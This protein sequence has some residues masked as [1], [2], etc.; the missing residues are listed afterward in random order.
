[1][2]RT[3]A[4]PADLA[5][6]PFRGSAA[7]DAGLTTRYQLRSAAWER[8]LRD[9]YIHRP[10]ADDPAIRVEALKLGTAPGA[11]VCGLTAAWAY[12]AWS[13]PP[14][15]T[16]PLEVTRPVRAPG[17]PAAGLTRRRLVL[18]GT[19]D[20]VRP[21]TGLSA[22]DEDV[23]ER[24]G[25]LFTSTFRTCFDLMRQR[26]LVEAVA[27]ADSF[28]FMCNMSIPLLDAYCADRRRW[29]NVRLA[30]SAVELA[31]PA[32]RSPGESRL[33]M[34]VVLAGFDEPLV[35]VPI[36]DLD[37]RHLATPDLL[38]RSRRLVG[39]EYDGEYHD[40]DEQ[41]AADRLRTNRLL[42]RTSIPLLRYDRTAVS[43]RRAVIVA[44]VASATGQRPL[45]TLDD[46]D[47]F[48]GPVRRLA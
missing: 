46:R 13:P 27:I 32:A 39:L 6:G 35:N 25:L 16:V 26:H 14:G 22:L 18:R 42:A 5:H 11:V 20:L 30:R 3:P 34:V 28:A 2:P 44:E 41:P 45:S 47:F 29:P 19:P 9:V 23:V 31:S 48:R 8:L 24:G 21:P 40:H 15:G 38:M 1:M 7:I 43:Q 4:V 17:T 36:L 37:D 33:R 12:G 10:L